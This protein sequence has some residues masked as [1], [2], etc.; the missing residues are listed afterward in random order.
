MLN[1]TNLRKL[2]RMERGAALAV[3]LLRHSIRRLRPRRMAKP[4]PELRRLAA[5]ELQPELLTEPR[6]QSVSLVVAEPKR[7]RTNSHEPTRRL[8]QHLQLLPLRVIDLGLVPVFR[9]QTGRFNHH[10]H[11]LLRHHQEKY[12]RFPHNSN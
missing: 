1:P 3:R 5:E 12:L 2:V 9:T 11:L 4:A 10:H 7:T 6:N 8:P